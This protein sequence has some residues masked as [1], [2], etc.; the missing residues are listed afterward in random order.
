MSSGSST[1][2]L[3]TSGETW[4]VRITSAGYGR[5]QDNSSLTGVSSAGHAC[6]GEL[7]LRHLR[8]FGQG[9][10]H[11][12]PGLGT[13]RV[14][15]LAEPKRTGVVQAADA[16]GYQIRPGAGQAEERRPARGISRI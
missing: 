4:W 14:N 12:I 1:A 9:G 8:H 16:N 6:C 2:A 10:V 5:R 11:G 13:H 3:F 15:I 7:P